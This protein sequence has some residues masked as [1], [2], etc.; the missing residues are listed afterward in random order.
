MIKWVV[1][2]LSGVVFTE[3]IKQA[4]RRI[5]AL[6]GKSE[7]EVYEYFH[8]IP[9]TAY[10]LGTQS[11]EDFWAEFGRHFGTDKADAAKAIFFDSYSLRQDAVEFAKR[12]RL[13]AKTAFFSFSPADRAKYHE[14]KY[15]FEKF[16]DRGVYASEVGL[17][18]TVPGAYSKMCAILGAE[19]SEVAYI[20]DSPVYAEAAK[21]AGLNAILYDL[22]DGFEKTRKDLRALGVEVPSRPHNPDDDDHEKL[23]M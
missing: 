5:G 11:P 20:D 16:F 7:K 13:S 19:P 14:D 21:S 15:G 8:G 18:K 12:V 22:A 3:G 23:P 9:S 1:F 4:S 17:D 10:R 6:V 2:D